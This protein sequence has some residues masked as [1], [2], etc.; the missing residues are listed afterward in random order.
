MNHFFNS[1]T[2][3]IADIQPDG[4]SQALDKLVGNLQSLLSQFYPYII[5]VISGLVIFWAAFIGIKWWQAGNQDKQREAKDYLKNFIIG[6][7]LIFVLS[8]VVVSLISWLGN[9]MST[10]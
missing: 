6:V 5:A 10:M 3:A 4:D 8:A 1:L 7:V 9:W 2:G